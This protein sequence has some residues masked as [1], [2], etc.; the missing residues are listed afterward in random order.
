MTITFSQC[1][2]IYGVAGVTAQEIFIAL[3]KT[4]KSIALVIEENAAPYHDVIVVDKVS[5][6]MAIRHTINNR[7]I[8]VVCDSLINL[9][10]LRDVQ[11]MDYTGKFS[12]SFELV[13]P[14]LKIERRNFPVDIK[15]K[16]KSPLDIALGKISHSRFLS[17]FNLV[18]SHMNKPAREKFRRLLVNHIRDRRNLEVIE[19]V[20]KTLKGSFKD[21]FIAQMQSSYFDNLIAAMWAVHRKEM[22][23]EEA[24]GIYKLDDSYEVVYLVKLIEEIT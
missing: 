10:T 6:L 2:A 22:T 13:K 19:F 1:A 4:I 11:P 12:V 8:V 24:K 7:M 23:A 14:K 5:K 18:T 9:E 21:P 20:Q 16:S 3:S 17:E 15:L